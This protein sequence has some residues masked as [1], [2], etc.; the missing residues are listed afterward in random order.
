MLLKSTPCAGQLFHTVTKTPEKTMLR[1]KETTGSQFNSMF[2]GCMLCLSQQK[3]MTLGKPRNYGSQ[4]KETETDKKNLKQPSKTIPVTYFFQLSSFSL[5]HLP[6][7][8]SNHPMSLS[9]GCS[10]DEVRAPTIQ[11]LHKSPSS[12][13]GTSLQPM[14]TQFLS[15]PQHTPGARNS[16]G[17]QQ[18]LMVKLVPSLERNYS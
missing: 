16:T 8:P 11:S 10:T 14:R 13:V 1:R 7:M 15:K 17:S 2:L 5:S 3:G 18:T 6:T 9:I 12:E 4:Q